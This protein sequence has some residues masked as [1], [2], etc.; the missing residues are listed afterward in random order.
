MPTTTMRSSVTQISPLVPVANG[1]AVV[2]RNFDDKSIALNMT[3]YFPAD[4]AVEGLFQVNRGDPAQQKGKSRE[5][6]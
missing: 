2:V 4:Y 6:D 5:E 3:I 1:V